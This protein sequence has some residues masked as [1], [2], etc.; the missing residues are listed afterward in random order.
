MAKVR[1]K[2]DTSGHIDLTVPAVAGTHS[3]SLSDVV[4]MAGMVSGDDFTASGDVQANQFTTDGNAKKAVWRAVKHN[5][6]ADDLYFKIARIVG[7]QSTRVS[8]TL[9]GRSEYGAGSIP[10]EAKAIFQNNNNS[11]YQGEV[12]H[13]FSSN[14]QKAVTNLSLVTVNT[15]TVDVYI[16]IDGY[17][18]LTAEAVVSGG[19]ITTYSNVTADGTTTEPTN[20][21]VLTAHTI[22]AG[23]GG[24]YRNGEVIEDLL[25][26]CD[27]GTLPGN[28]A[29]VQSVGGVQHLTSSY[30]D[31][32]GSVVSNYVVPSG[33]KTVVYT[34][35]FQY[36]RTDTTPIAHCR[37]YYK[38]GTGSWTEASH[39][40][41]TLAGSHL[42][43]HQIFVWPFTVGAS[44]AYTNDG[45]LTESTPTLSFK[46]QIREYG[47]GNEAKLHVSDW[48]NGTGSDKYSR[49]LVG[50]KAIAGS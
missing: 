42:H 16:K 26:V 37:L 43:G 40:S 1:I 21:R 6:T 35:D 44:T 15:T 12:F 50:V 25:T 38:V 10:G 32:N 46:W 48:W 24:T 3:C 36:S 5:T 33:T 39:A 14:G 13:L 9:T 28:T 18:E 22:S 19:S 29:T 45:I 27:G 31:L 41:R 30:A 17:A 11:V 23:S 49:P 8:I 47:S 20:N 4:S 2:G 34:F 7:G